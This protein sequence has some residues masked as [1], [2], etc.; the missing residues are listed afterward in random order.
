ML[1]KNLPVHVVSSDAMWMPFTI[2][3]IYICYFV[4]TLKLNIPFYSKINCFVLLDISCLN[5]VDVR[6]NGCREQPPR[7]APWESGL[8]GHFVQTWPDSECSHTVQC[9]DCSDLN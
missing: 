5:G 8:V 9:L 1:M 6:Y 4:M 7:S 2:F 3:N